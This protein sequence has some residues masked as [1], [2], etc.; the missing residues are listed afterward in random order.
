[1]MPS[2]PWS[3]CAALSLS[4]ISTSTIKTSVHPC[5]TGNMHVSNMS[6]LAVDPS[7]SQGCPE[8]VGAM[9]GYGGLKE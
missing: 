6:Y 8:E 5:H 9:R 4:A 2:L 3:I 7:L 1:M